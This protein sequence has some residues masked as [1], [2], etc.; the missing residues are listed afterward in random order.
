MLLCGLP[1]RAGRVRYNIER[2]K[3]KPYNYVFEFA[4]ILKTFQ[5]HV[6]LFFDYNGL[7]NSDSRNK[8]V[9]IELKMWVLG[10]KYYTSLKGTKL[11]GT[12]D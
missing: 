6:F 9:N 1:I 11:L 5:I 4:N 12:N 7:E 8:G 2:I 10:L 3:C